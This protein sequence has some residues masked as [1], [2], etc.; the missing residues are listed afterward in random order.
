M[1]C[2]KERSSVRD[3][4]NYSSLDDF[5]QKNAP[6]LSNFQITGS[7]GG[8]FTTLHGTRIDIAAN[9]FIDPS[10]KAITGRVD[11]AFLDLYEKSEMLFSGIST[12]SNAWPLKSGGEFFIKA[13]VDGKSVQIFPGKSIEISQPANDI[14]T[15]M[16][17][18]IGIIDSVNMVNWIPTDSSGLVP[19]Q[20]LKSYI[21]SLYTFSSPLE[22]GTW[23]NSD[24]ALYFSNFNTTTLAIVAD[25]DPDAFDTDVF[26]IFHDVNSMIHVYKN[27]NDNQFPYAYAPIGFDCS[28]VAIGV[29]DG[30]LYSSFTPL[31]I[32]ENQTVHF[33]LAKTN[34]EAFK[35]QLV[36]LNN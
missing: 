36:L 4:D 9:S 27:W 32:K 35:Q 13:S 25:D 8:T 30:K 6:L 33:N 14:D 2:T 34:T 24:N 5:Y 3:S 12:A 28:I 29:K 31:T 23:S 20:D 21:F 26:L 19:A 1:S 11:I 17:P 7:E 15:L 18:F 22:N 10:G 16:S